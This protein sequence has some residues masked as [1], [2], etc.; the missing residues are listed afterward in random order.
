MVKSWVC[1]YNN[2]QTIIFI[3]LGIPSSSFDSQWSPATPNWES[4]G[5]QVFRLSSMK[6][7]GECVSYLAEENIKEQGYG[8]P[9]CKT[10]KKLPTQI[11]LDFCLNST[12]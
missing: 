5:G 12:I 10:D 11:Y 7:Q 9:P 1:C 2:F 4:H 6:L 3:L 8:H